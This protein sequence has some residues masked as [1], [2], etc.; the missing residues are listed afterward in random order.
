MLYV[1]FGCGL[2]VVGSYLMKSFFW[3]D[4]P[5][6]IAFYWLDFPLYLCRKIIPEVSVE[7]FSP[8][9]VKFLGNFT[10]LKSFLD[11]GYMAVR[12]I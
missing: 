9:D 3:K 4:D 6:Q 11:A 1:D 7:E 8:N 5:S 2:Y 10:F 12:V